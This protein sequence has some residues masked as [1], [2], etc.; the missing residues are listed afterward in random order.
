MSEPEEY[1]LYCPQKVLDNFRSIDS[2]LNQ[3]A[4]IGIK[5]VEQN[6]E[7]YSLQR[8]KEAIKRDKCY[9]FYRSFSGNESYILVRL[10][11]NLSESDEQYFNTL[12]GF[13]VYYSNG[14]KIVYENID[15]SNLNNLGFNS[16]YVFC[17]KSLSNLDIDYLNKYRAS[18]QCIFDGQTTNLIF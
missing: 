12:E 11:L 14:Y 13:T 15:G 18:A 17:H 6:T 5:S 16:M 7:K 2:R 3:L 9:T 8:Q 1:C 4:Q 10:P